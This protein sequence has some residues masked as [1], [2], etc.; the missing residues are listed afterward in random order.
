[1]LAARLEAPNWASRAAA[2][3]GFALAGCDRARRSRAPAVGRGRRRPGR[4]AV[5]RIEPRSSRA[6]GFKFAARTIHHGGELAGAT[7]TCRLLRASGRR[8]QQ[9]VRL[10]SCSH[11]ARAE[12]CRASAAEAA[13]ADGGRRGNSAQARL[14]Q[15]QRTHSSRYDEESRGA[16]LK[17][18]TASLAASWTS[19][20]ARLASQRNSSFRGSTPSRAEVKRT[21]GPTGGRTGGKGCAAA[22]LMADCC[23]LADCS[24]GAAANEKD[25]TKRTNQQLEF[26]SSRDLTKRTGCRSRLESGQVLRRLPQAK[27]GRD[28]AGEV[29]A[30]ASGRG[31]S[32]RR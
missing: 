30:S 21:D 17:V 29:A 20:A 2:R 12:P 5:R 26:R 8:S 13:A 1:M 31:S 18:R 27:H 23:W 25:G 15:R 9:S 3:L 16:P 14:G 7:S 10:R 32:R 6:D 28:G 4:A 19:R 24:A 11:E 22:A